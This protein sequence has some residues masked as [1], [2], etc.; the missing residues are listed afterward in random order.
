MQKQN[1]GF[2]NLMNGLGV[3]NGNEVWCKC[4][5]LSACVRTLVQVYSLTHS[6]YSNFS[7][8]RVIVVHVYEWEERRVKH[9]VTSFTQGHAPKR[10]E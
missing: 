1:L 5:E 6:L 3:G 7:K 4:T 2:V 8:N 10:V 9:I